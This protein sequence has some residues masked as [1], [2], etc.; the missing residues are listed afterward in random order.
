MS[1]MISSSEKSTA[2]IG[3]VERR[4]ERGRRHRPGSAISPASVLSPSRRAMTEAMPGARCAPT[5]LRGRARCRCA[6]EIEQQTN[7]PITVRGRDVAVADE[8]GGLGLRDAAAARVREV[9]IEEE[10]ADQRAEQSAPRSGATRPRPAG[11][12][13]AASRP[14]RRMNATTTSPTTAPITTLSTSTSWFSCWRSSPSQRSALPCR[15]RRRL[16][17]GR[18]R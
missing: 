14:V 17:T 5:D 11:Y 3:R 7:L 4:G 1:P 8:E 15:A 13:C 10:P 2:A 6:S 12:M 18:G 16:N 9:A